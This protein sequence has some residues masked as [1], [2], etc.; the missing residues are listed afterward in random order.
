[1]SEKHLMHNM[2]NQYQQT[3]SDDSRAEEA[4][5]FVKFKERMQRLVKQL[6]RHRPA[7]TAK[8][9]RWN[10]CESIELSLSACEVNVHLKVLPLSLEKALEIRALS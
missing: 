10:E 8:H 5:E 2:H 6:L 3:S 9:S 7:G 4:L 1:M